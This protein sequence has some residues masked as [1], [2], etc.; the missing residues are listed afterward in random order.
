VTYSIVARDPETGQLG[1]A[2]QSRSFGAV[3]C[4][5]ARAGVGAVATQSFADLGYG[6]LGLDLMQVGK[7]PAQ[8]LA[9]LRAADELEAF[10]QVAIVDGTARTAVHTG[11]SCIAEAGHAAGDGYSVQANMMASEDVWP[12]MAKAFESSVGTLAVRLLAAMDAAQAAGGDWRGQQAAAL[13]VVAGESSGRPWDDRLV[14][15]RV[16]DSRT[17]LAELRRLVVLAEGYRR[18]LRREPELPI[19]DAVAAAAE[20]GFQEVDVL[21]AGVIAGSVGDVDEGR[22]YL[23]RLL[24][25]D[26][27]YLEVLRRR[28]SLAD[29][30]GVEPLEG[31]P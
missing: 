24:E 19:R 25:L 10:R 4:I 30:Y 26:S 5:W 7:T 18:L 11:S 29:A 8:A 21:W 28:R 2:V 14:D 23:D 6:P 22:R 9:A 15:V 16:D 20:A 17:P 12:A 3:R 31:A 13:L 1:G 27:R